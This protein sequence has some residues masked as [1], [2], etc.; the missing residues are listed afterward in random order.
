MKKTRRMP[1]RPSRVLDRANRAIDPIRR[2]RGRGTGLVLLLL[3]LLVVAAHAAEEFRLNRWTTDGGGEMRC[4]GGG[5]ELSGTVGQPDAAFMSGGALELVGGFW[6][7]PL[8]GDCNIDA[9]VDLVDYELFP[10]CLSGPTGDILL[11]CACLD[12]DRDGDLDLSDVA[13]FQRMF[14]GNGG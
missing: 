4:T 5:F 10:S 8:A 13:V 11:E 12:L 9:A 1:A 2:L 3:G 7:A 6:F 14:T